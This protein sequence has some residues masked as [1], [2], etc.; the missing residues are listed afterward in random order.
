MSI[1]KRQVRAII[2]VI[3]E[4]NS[5]ILTFFSTHH[6]LSAEKLLKQ[7]GVEQTVVPT[8]RELSGN[9]GI[10]IRID[11]ADADRARRLLADAGI[12]VEGIHPSPGS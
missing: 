8:P 11:A 6:A 4:M 2:W 12:E 10:A 3:C 9:C 5:Q 7:N 1:C